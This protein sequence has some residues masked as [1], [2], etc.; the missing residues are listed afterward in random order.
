MS[1][2]P[3]RPTTVPAEARWLTGDKQWE[4]GKI[5]ADGKKQGPFTYW[6][7]DGSLV[8]Q[9]HFKDDVPNGSF[10]RYHETGEVFQSCTLVDGRT[11]G[12][13]REFHRET[14]L[15]TSETTFDSA[16]NETGP[17]MKLFVDG[18]LFHPGA[19]EARGQ[20]IRGNASG[21]WTYRRGSSTFEIDFGR[22]ATTDEIKAA[23]LTANSPKSAEHWFQIYEHF[24]GENKPIAALLALIRY[25][26][27]EGERSTL[28]TF[29]RARTLA[30]SPAAETAQAEHFLRTSSHRSFDDQER[31]AAA[32]HKLIAY[33][34]EILRGGNPETIL[35]GAAIDFDQQ[36]LSFLASDLIRTAMRF[37]PEN[38]EFNFTACLIAMSIGRAK[39]ARRRQAAATEHDADQ[40]A[41]LENSLDFCFRPF[42]FIDPTE[43]FAKTEPPYDPAV[44]EI[45]KDL[46][47]IR[48][49]ITDSL[50]WLSVVRKHIST[51]LHPEVR[52]QFEKLTWVPPDFSELVGSQRMTQQE[53]FVDRIEGFG[54]PELLM[55]AHMMWRFACT[56]CWTCGMKD[57]GIP[58]EISRPN[59]L[60]MII[61]EAWGRSLYLHDVENSGSSPLPTFVFCDRNV[62]K[63]HS[64]LLVWVKKD[65]D[66]YIGALRFLTAPP[67][68][69]APLSRDHFAKFYEPSFDSTS[70]STSEP[71]SEPMSEPMSEPILESAPEPALESELDLTEDS[72][73]VDFGNTSHPDPVVNS[74][75]SMP[76][77]E[78]TAT[79]IEL[80][81]PPVPAHLGQ[82]E[83]LDEIPANAPPIQLTQ[84]DVPDEL[85]APSVDAKSVSNSDDSEATFVG[86][87]TDIR[88]LVMKETPA[89][90]E[91]DLEITFDDPNSG[92]EDV[93]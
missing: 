50:A 60:P 10:V 87:R 15:L 85:D 24:I 11:V 1:L 66:G 70:A 29:L 34:D 20:S 35:K 7:A 64:N 42:F 22:V 43:D 33:M 19:W 9:C 30:L 53:Q 5:D 77:I 91:S 59:L 39:E 28:F 62:A 31:E 26:A 92:E 74:D 48:E 14:G 73:V 57:I 51:R 76:I 56:L 6:R 69:S 2:T 90:S 63:I 3:Q 41:F 23:G 78:L 67:G 75:V 93:A 47:D 12:V 40:G 72:S 88:S 45:T 79:G 4:F 54:V 46:A 18:Y 68:E 61:P 65:V 37:S 52:E 71:K 36:G 27:E 38:T 58:E 13:S 89:P 82:I 25:T 84:V 80:P 44:V 16:G 17:A 49:K 81:T 21:V 32:A 55:E 83:A 8:N 86:T